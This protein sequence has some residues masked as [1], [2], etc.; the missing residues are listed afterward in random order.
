MRDEGLFGPQ[1]VT[2]QLHADPTMWIAG[3]CGLY[4]QALHPLAV[5]AVV[6][7]SRFREDPLGRL[8]RTAN[9]VAA[10]TYGTTAE[11]ESVAARVRQVH[12]TL[13]ATDRRTVPR[14]AW[15]IRTCCA[16]CIA[17]RSPRS[18][19]WCGMRDSR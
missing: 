12:R 8:M 11:A 7:N 9:F 1:T 6:Q 3:I 10:T 17:P 14:S 16:G 13:R 4:L 18:P 5:A 2:W 15:T 19:A